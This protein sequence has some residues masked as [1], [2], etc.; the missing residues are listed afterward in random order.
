MF[1]ILDLVVNYIVHINSMKI[2][3]DL[4]RDLKVL[5]IFRLFKMVKSQYLNG[6]HRIV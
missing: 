5:R 2:Y 6:F 4:A 1:S 3:A